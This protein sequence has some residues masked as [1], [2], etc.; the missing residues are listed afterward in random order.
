ML[1]PI[2]TW[3]DIKGYEGLYQV[4]NLG[5]IRSKHTGKWIK[6]KC[7]PVNKRYRKVIL[8][9][10]EKREAKLV[11]RLVAEAFIPNT[12]SLPYVN[13]KDE[14]PSNNMAVNLEWCTQKYNMN[15]G[16]VKERV[17]NAS[18][19]RKRSQ[20]SIDL[21]IKR[22]KKKIYCVE[23]D[24]IFN[25]LKEAAKYEGVD[26]AEITHEAKGEQNTCGGY[27]WEYKI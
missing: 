17:G 8:C 22:Q 2:R 11:H 14:N 1:F 23:L 26:S 9:D 5:E 6:L 21:Q 20:Y 27:H 12:N 15:Y 16:T 3:K 19:G 13:H 25:S 10:N 18:K 7:S 24:M 4:S